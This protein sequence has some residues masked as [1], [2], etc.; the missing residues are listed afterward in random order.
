MALTAN[1]DDED[2]AEKLRRQIYD[3]QAAQFAP[4][5]A[6]YQAPTA[7]AAPLEAAPFAGAPTST[8]GPVE[9][10]PFEPPSP[11]QDPWHG[12]QPPAPIEAVYQPQPVTGL[13]S[14]PLPINEGLIAEPPPTIGPTPTSTTGPYASAPGP[15]EA[16]A[17]ATTS[18]PSAM[19]AVPAG[20]DATKWNDPTHN[21]PKY[22][23]GRIIAQN[24]NNEAAVLAAVQ[25][26]YPGAEWRSKDRLFIPQGIE[27][28]NEFDVLGQR[29]TGAWNPQWMPVGPATTTSSAPAAT[30]SR[31]AAA[32]RSSGGINPQSLHPGT[33]STEAE[34]AISKV[35]SGEWTQ[36]QADQYLG[37][38]G[39]GSAAGGGGAGGDVTSAVEQWLMKQ[40]QQQEADRESKVALDKQVR[41][42]ISQRLT[43]AGQPVNE[44]DEYIA[45]PLSAARDE[46]QRA[47]QTERTRLAERLYAQG[48]GALDSNAL[49]QQIQQSG[50]RNAGNL[51]SLRAGLIGKELTARRGE[52]QSLLQM[53]LA[54][55]D[56]DQARQTQLMIQAIDN[57]LRREFKG[58][59]LAQFMA[60]LDQNAALAGLNG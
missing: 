6:T 22:Q 42:M 7:S 20:Y 29:S 51:S 56:A 40:I 9:S 55:G 23:I 28:F 33:G 11:Y 19:P 5:E 30:S 21:T 2:P 26:L 10:A 60:Q 34:W 53:A 39:G 24:P 47:E 8:A 59:D 44:S 45:A 12:Y 41:D 35:L 1:V 37:A 32:A 18:A 54:Q 13:D 48:G 3:E 43:A 25:A 17:P 15:T 16:S 46:T 36:A 38:G 58:I 14:P 4:A 49:T 50:E 31:P 27:G 57:Q 52:L